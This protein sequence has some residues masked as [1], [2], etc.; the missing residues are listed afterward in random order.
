MAIAIM[1][2]ND[3]EFECFLAQCL[4]EFE[5]KQSYLMQEFGMGR[6]ERFNVDLKTGIIEFK[7]NSVVKIVANITP[8]GS[9]STNN[10]SWMWAWGNPS[11][12]QAL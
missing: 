12:P 5:Q 1:S 4:E 9:Y 7:E 6:Y 2:M 10:S 3:N 8:I 11:I